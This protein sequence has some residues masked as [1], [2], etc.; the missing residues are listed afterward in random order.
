MDTSPTADE[1]GAAS[2]PLPAA[3]PAF[4]PL[5]ATTDFGISAAPFRPARLLAVDDDDTNREMLVRR[6]QK[7]GYAQDLCPKSE[8]F[9]YRREMNL[10][11]H[12]RLTDQE[13]NDTIAGM[14]SS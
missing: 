5:P 9:F 3:V 6:L 2:A 10:P 14:A 8:K 13:I 11:M 12:P 4:R 1:A 7:L